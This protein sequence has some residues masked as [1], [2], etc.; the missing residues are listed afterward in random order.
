VK[1]PLRSL[2]T[3]IAFFVFA[4][5][6]LASLSVTFVSLNSIDTFLR[7]RISQKFPTVLDHTN[8]ALESWYDAR[9]REMDVFS[10]SDVVRGRLPA[11]VGGERDQRR[12][13]ARA[14]A[15]V[16]QYLAYVLEGFPQ[17]VAL[18]LLDDDHQTVLWVGE[19]TDLPPT[20]LDEPMGVGMSRMGGSFGTAWDR[21]QLTSTAVSGPDGKMIGSLH[22]LLRIDTLKDVLPA[23]ELGDSGR[24]VIVDAEGH[25]VSGSQPDSEVD[26]F[27]PPAPDDQGKPVV[28]DYISAT[29]ERMVGASLPFSRLGWSI[30][31]EQS[32]DAA[33]GP[34][35]EGNGRLLLINLAIVLCMALAAFRIAVSIVRP[36]EALSNAA[37][38]ISD[39]ERDVDIPATRSS[40]EVALLT[41][42]FSNMT[43]RLTNNASELEASHNAVE[44][45]NEQLQ[46]QNEELS[47]ANEVLEQLSITDG[48]TKLHNH[49]YF[50]QALTKEIKRS[51]RNGR[52]LALVL[53][54]VDYFKRWN[55]QLGHAA[56]DEIL[57]SM[58]E[59]MNQ[60]IRASDILARYG[61]EEFALLSP[62]TDLEGAVMMAEK[63][64]ARIATTRFSA[65]PE[66]ESESVTVSVGVA[67][68]SDETTDLFNAAD[69]ALYRAKAEGRDCV[70][71]D[72][73]EAGGEGA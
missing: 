25:F 59:E 22:A 13:N 49:A 69:R 26:D 72:D 43:T 55:D 24:I 63:V 35:V 23:E 42:A 56:G 30:V 19:P 70:V 16:E 39:G 45:A 33:F 47:R 71:V 5:T 28:R 6:L 50:Q 37:K 17:Y 34:V 62:D 54:D 73:G 51:S 10:R 21:L 40:D 68:L 60:V 31:V 44:K 27:S 11:L 15:E 67:V 2:P 32:H 41:R 58:A 12:E 4:A 20:L 29:G 48:L 46:L 9:L 1:N 65:V 66:G 57:R 18:F 53:I 38:R 36:I 7:G 64:R 14:A 3:R 8:T 61:G 52:S